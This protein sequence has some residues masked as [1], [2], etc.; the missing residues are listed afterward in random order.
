MNDERRV[1]MVND[2]VVVSSKFQDTRRVIADDDQNDHFVS[3]A[4]SKRLRA[5]F[6]GQSALKILRQTFKTT[7]SGPLTNLA[8]PT[9]SASVCNHSNAGPVST[10][11]SV[12]RAHNDVAPPVA[13]KYIFESKWC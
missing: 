13:S 6:N 7:P 8:I 3:S 12:V 9:S 11:T 10:S 2:A 1:I 5:E 4:E